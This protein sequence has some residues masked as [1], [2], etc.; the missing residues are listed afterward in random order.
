[1]CG[2]DS[3]DEESSEPLLSQPTHISGPAPPRLKISS[4]NSI[5]QRAQ[6]SHC[7][8]QDLRFG[9]LKE[10]RNMRHDCMPSWTTTSCWTRGVA[11]AVRASRGTSGYLR[12]EPRMEGV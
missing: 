9:R 7:H 4:T 8:I 11:V 12:P 10:F 2:D 3:F 6:R 1:M 5:A